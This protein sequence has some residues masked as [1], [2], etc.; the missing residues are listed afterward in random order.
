MF[1]FR[2]FKRW[3]AKTDKNKTDLGLF[4]SFFFHNARVIFFFRFERLTTRRFGRRPR[5]IICRAYRWNNNNIMYT[6]DALLLVDPIIRY[7]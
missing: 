4:V 7:G 3:R 1:H 6:R 5:F 2:F